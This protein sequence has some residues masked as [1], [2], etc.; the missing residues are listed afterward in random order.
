MDTRDG[1]IVFIL[2]VNLSFPIF[3]GA[4][5]SLNINANFDN[6]VISTIDLLSEGIVLTNATSITLN[7]NDNQIE[8]YVSPN[9]I[10]S[11]WDANG[12][13]FQVQLNQIDKFFNTKFF[14]TNLDVT[15]SFG[16]SWTIIGELTFINAAS[17]HYIPTSKIISEFRSS[18][19]YAHGKMAYYL[20]DSD[21]KYVS[22]K[23]YPIDIFFSYNGTAY[24]SIT[25][26]LSNGEIYVTFG[27]LI[28]N[29]DYGN[30]ISWYVGILLGTNTYG[31]PN[32]FLWIMRIFIAVSILAT[33]WLIKDLLR[34]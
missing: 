21:T 33:V 12:L 11:S 8:T 14:L 3:A 30:F 5:T 17:T 23:Q 29:A 6:S 1:L 2:I 24:S 7:L 15:N 31:M 13:S 20:V 19:G 25:D 32:E 4:L 26:A 10:Y 34:L 16:V 9:R 27:S 18:R 22:T 28:T